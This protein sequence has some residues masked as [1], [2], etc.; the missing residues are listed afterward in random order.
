MN[1]EHLKSI[2]KAVSDRYTRFVR[3]WTERPNTAFSP[4]MWERET[5]KRIAREQETLRFYTERG[6]KKNRLISAILELKWQVRS[7]LA[8]CFIS[9]SISTFLI[10]DNNFSFRS[11]SYREFVSQLDD[12]MLFGTAWMTARTGQLTQRPNLFLIHM[13]D[14]M[15]DMSEEARLRRI[16]EIYL[17]IPG[18]S[19]WRRLA[20]KSAEIKPPT[21]SESDQLE[22]YQRWTLYALAPAAVPLN[23][24]EKASM[25]SE[26][27][28]HWGSLTHQ[29]ISLYAY[30]KYQGEDVDT[31]LDHLSE[32]IAFEA[33]WDIRVTDLYL[34]RVAFLLSVGRPDLVRPRW[35]ERIIAK[36]DTDGGWSADWHGWGPDILRF[37]WKQQGANAH[38]T[39]QGMWALYML[40]Y[41]YPE[42]IK[43]NYR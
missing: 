26:N 36:Q 18:D 15:A 17:E 27:A 34:Q 25:F 9:F 43:Q 28:H 33:I 20:D 13:I 4:K 19:L 24:E 8:I 29:L 23:A 40:K 37:Q 31:L 14:D 7:I 21:R 3:F 42:W 2:Y 1:K 5:K 41:R 6:E 22:D 10:L 35:V 39:V 11:K 16:V 12:S 32:R 38:T 30:W